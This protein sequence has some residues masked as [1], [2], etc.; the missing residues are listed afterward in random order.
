MICKAAFC[1]SVL[2]GVCATGI[3]QQADTPMMAEVKQIISSVFT[4]D[5]MATLQYLDDHLGVRLTG[6]EQYEHAAQWAMN[7]FRANGIPDVHLE[8]FT[9][10]SGWQ[11]GSATGEV[12]SPASR[13]LHVESVGWSPSTPP[14]GAQGE[15]VV[16]T[17]IS[18]S[19]LAANAAAIRNHIVLLDTDRAFVA[20][21]N[22]TYADLQAAYRTFRDLGVPAMLLPDA[23][24]NNVL[25]D[26][27][28]VDNG[29]AKI[30]PLPLAEIGMEDA[31]RLRRLMAQGKVTINITIKND[32]T[33]PQ[34]VHN[35]VA[36]MRGSEKP[37]EWVL[38]GGH[39]DTWDLSA[40]VQDNGSGAV[41]VL[42]T[43]KAIAA[44]SSRPRR[45]IRFVLW[46]GEEPGIMGSRTY[47]KAHAAELDHCVAVVNSDHGVGRP[48]GFKLA[49]RADVS[50]AMEPVEATYLYG[51]GATANSL[52]MTYDSDNGPFILHGVP[53][54]D[55]W[56]DMTH[57]QDIHHK[58]SDT[59]DKVNALN[60]N[61]DT[62]VVAATTYIVANQPAPI[63]PHIDHAHVAEILKKENQTGYLIAH[64]DW[65][66]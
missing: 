1:V 9:I 31:L 49:D 8:A 50:R 3:A 17:D 7:Q 39:L 15:V 44:L 30:Q 11:R 19:N 57:Y 6:T 62:A 10:A 24:P 14:G 45:S 20:G 47:V 52:E 40:A 38:V 21:F 55:L 4:S 56:V 58:S 46:T 28:D 25:G 54:L 29:D 37:D 2:L 35:V 33:G 48:L 18:P 61:A 13:S 65:T 16:V 59:F 64:G 12:I 66:P 53:T 5:S 22:Q 41:M 26:W 23:V 43:A 42:E 32:I 34:T 60:M 63:A 27:V 51:L 36:E